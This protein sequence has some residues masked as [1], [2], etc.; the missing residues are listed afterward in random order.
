VDAGSA[1]PS[2]EGP[3]YL[4]CLLS[5]SPWGLLVAASF[6]VLGLAAAALG[7]LRLTTSESSSSSAAI[8]AP[9][10]GIELSVEQ[11]TVSVLGG[12]S[13]SPVVLRHRDHSTF[14]HGPS[15]QRSIRAGVL[16]VTSHCPTILLGSCSSDYQ[17]IVPDNVPVTVRA[18]GGGITLDAYHGSADLETNGGRIRVDAF[19]GFVLHA[20]TLSGRIDVGTSCSPQRLELRSSEGDISVVVPQG[21]YEVEAASSSGRT[22]LR[23]LSSESGAPWSISAISNS[24]DVGVEAAR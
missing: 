22:R 11:G 15:E 6:S 23:G 17:L 19:C 3:S 20:L 24:G 4:R 1:P 13:Q 18:P 12:G 7:A 10:T 14:G 21:R 8:R 2:R 5:L 9:L 16:R